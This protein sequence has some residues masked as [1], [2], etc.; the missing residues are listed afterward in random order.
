MRPDC[1]ERR[2]Q[3]TARTRPPARPARGPRPRRCHARCGRDL[4]RCGRIQSARPQRWSPTYPAWSPSQ[5]ITV[6]GVHVD[7]FALAEILE[8][9]DLTHF[10][11]AVHERH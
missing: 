7:R 2:L 1:G 11:L 5:L 3:A 4:P 6:P 9:E 8:L 10:D